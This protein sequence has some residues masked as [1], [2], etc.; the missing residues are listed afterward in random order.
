MTAV[1]LSTP[2]PARH[3]APTARATS[4][5]YLLFERPDL[6]VAERFLTDFGLH[7]VEKR[8]DALYLR[9]RDSAPWCYGVSHGSTARFLGMGF[10]VATR[11]ELQ[12]LTQVHGASAIAPVVAPGGGEM[13][14]LL[15]PNGL[16]VEV[17]FGRTAV[18]AQPRRAPLPA[19]HDKHLPRVNETQRPPATPPEILKLGHVAIEAAAYQDVAGWYT[20]H[21]GFIPSDI[22]V[23]PDGSPGVT[24]MRLDLGDTPA[25]H[26][27]LALA[28]S[29]RAALSHCAF[30]VVDVDA[31][32][33]GQRVLRDRGW[34]HA[35]GMGRHVLG[36]QLFDYWSDPW[37]THHEH[38]CDGDVFTANHPTGIHPF[39]ADAM[40]QWGQ[41]MPGSFIK[42]RPSLA[43]VRT[44]IHS[45]R[46]VPDVTL[47]KMLTIARSL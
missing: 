8:A 12:A 44:L 9:A 32:G 26:H 10:T 37:G 5:A 39:S 1:T 42:P 46:T 36:S 11:A 16:V 17:V 25:D 22:Q 30:E 43:L 38:Y 23:L 20:R 3:S 40:A 34:H 21:L 2:Q 33:M 6:D 41:T 29:F 14:R 13:V 4:L 24:F 35:W 18:A 15:D 31:I 7:T 28:Q 27:T 45:L 19:N 47:K